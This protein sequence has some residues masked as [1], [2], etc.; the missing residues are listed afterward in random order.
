[1]EQQKSEESIRAEF[2]VKIQQLVKELKELLEAKQE[3]EKEYKEYIQ[4]MLEEHM[5]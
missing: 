4:E 5:K 2:N 1:M 3:M